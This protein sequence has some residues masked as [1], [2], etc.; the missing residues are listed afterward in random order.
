MNTSNIDTTNPKAIAKASK[1]LGTKAFMSKDY[2]EAIKHFTEAIAWDAEN[3]ALWSNRSAC[4]IFEKEYEK[5]IF[6]AKRCIK[7][8][9]KWAK[10]HLRLGS[11]CFRSKK[12]EDALKAFQSALELEP[13]SK[14]AQKNVDMVEV[15]MKKL[16]LD[17]K[18][19]ENDDSKTS[20]TE[21]SEDVAVGIDLGTTNSCVAVYRNG[22]VEII[23]NSEGK[24]TTPSVVSFM[25]DGTR[26]VGEAA[27]KQA[28]SN[29]QN[30]LYETKRLIGRCWDDTTVQTDVRKLPFKIIKSNDSECPM[31]EVQG[32]EG[33]TEVYAPEQISAMV[34]TKMK[35]T[36]EKYLGRPVTKAVIT[37][38]AYFSDAQRNATV[39][40]GKI[41]GLE[42]LR[43]INEPTA[44]AMA[45]GIGASKKSEENKEEEKKVKRVLVFDLGGGTFD[46]SLL[47]IEGGIFEVLST[48]GD[49]HLGGEDFDDLL[50][51]H[52]CDC[53]RRKHPKVASKVLK[54]PRILRRIRREAEQCK[55]TLSAAM[56]ATLELEDLS[57][58]GVDEFDFSM[59]VTRAKFERLC[60][61][62]F[63]RTID[64]VKRVMKEGKVSVT[65]VDDV[66]LVGGSTRIPV[67]QSKLRAFFNDMKLSKSVNPDE[68]VAFGAAVQAA[69]LTGVKDEMTS[70]LL[71]VDVTPLSLGIETV[72]KQMSVIIARNTS[73]P[74]EITKTYTTEHNFQESIEIPVFEGERQNV[75]GNNKLG[76]FTVSGIQRAKRGVPKVAVTFKLNSDGILNVKAVDQMTGAENA[77][78][79]V[80]RG[81][82]SDEDVERMINDAKRFAEEDSLRAEQME[83][84]H[85]LEDLVF[86]CAD[87]VGDITQAE[88][89]RHSRKQKVVV[90]ALKESIAEVR[91]WIGKVRGGFGA[92]DVKGL[93]QSKET[94]LKFR[95]R[96]EM[97]YMSFKREC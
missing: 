21:T 76:E 57:A 32:S 22:N 40:A 69:I 36:A 46:V 13:T 11:A 97:D 23:S 93:R 59:V 96:L 18:D 14:V 85:G 73:I 34:L 84:V 72:G 65:E 95:K 51:K 30:T 79:I 55:R 42:V 52:I 3:R 75:D 63:K 54:S 60:A 27:K 2:K 61:E 58:P 89:K 90:K 56:S 64:T 10:A 4:Y 74:C 70:Q 91:V 8:S 25:P 5:A 92:G 44:A 1:E 33:K 82:V 62:P 35:T 15:A 67:I 49:T 39:T 9:P 71:L 45:Y 19:E 31:I 41:A 7:L 28:V 43:I 26:L 53:I 29:S 86:E 17:V 66:V 68:A 80:N 83:I 81:R 88:E 24:R 12:Y 6:D 47:Q 94:S 37:V 50:Q 78:R 87:M 20:T 48:G 16:S 77:I 38:P